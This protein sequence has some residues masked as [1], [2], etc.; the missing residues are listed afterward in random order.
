MSPSAACSI[1]AQHIGE[2]VVPAVVR[3]GHV[4]FRIVAPDVRQRRIETA[5]HVQVRLHTA[6]CGHHH[7]VRVVRRVHRQHQIEVGEPL[8]GDLPRGMAVER[9]RHSRRLWTVIAGRLRGPDASPRCQQ[10]QQRR[11]PQAQPPRRGAGSPPRRS[12]ERQILPKHTAV[13]R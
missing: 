2:A 6:L 5:E 9:R 12:G 4:Q 8:G 13:M 11:R 10:N 3:I 7:Q 1:I